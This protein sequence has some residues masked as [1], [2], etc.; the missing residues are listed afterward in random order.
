MKT[1]NKYLTES[2]IK[3][4]SKNLKDI[5]LKKKSAIYEI[6]D[7][8]VKVT[9]IDNTLILT[10]PGKEFDLTYKLSQIA[11]SMGKEYNQVGMGKKTMKFIIDLDQ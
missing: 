10:Y 4:N 5:I 7:I 6:D 1:I 3:S 11:D 8:T 9:K 2:K